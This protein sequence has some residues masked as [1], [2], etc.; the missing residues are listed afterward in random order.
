MSIDVSSEKSLGFWGLLL[1]L[2]G[3]FVPYVGS[4]L[5]FVGL[6]LVLIALKGIGDKIGNDRPFK[7]YLYGVIFSFAGLILLIIF[8]F[9]I[10]GI[11]SLHSASEMGVSSSREI[12]PGES[13]VIHEE[14]GN[15]PGI[16]LEVIV[17][18]AVIFLLIIAASAYFRSRAWG[19]MYE[20]TEVK[21]FKDA[22]TWMKW[23]AFTA[24]IIIGLLLVLIGEIMAIVA[25]NKMPAELGEEPMSVEETLW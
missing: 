5:A 2:I 18:A 17:L 10:F 7:N 22:S 8:I 14:F 11:Y 23:G 1:S 12:A 25:F 3:G 21:E 9:G 24:V 6:I 4:V 19:A 15:E 16:G 13:V 20:I